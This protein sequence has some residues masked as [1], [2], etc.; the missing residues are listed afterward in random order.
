MF[1]HAPVTWTRTQAHKGSLRGPCKLTTDQL[2]RVIW[3]ANILSWV[4]PCS[5]SGKIIHCLRAQR[6]NITT[7][8]PYVSIWRPDDIAAD[9]QLDPLQQGTYQ[10]CHAEGHLTGGFISQPLPHLLDI[11][12]PLPVIAKAQVVFY[13]VPAS[14]FTSPTS[15]RLVWMKQL[16]KNNRLLLMGIPKHASIA[17]SSGN[18]LCIFRDPALKALHSRI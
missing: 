1:L 6:L 5:S 16:K 12:L 13:Y 10:S 18:L 17:E 15:V 11:I 9:S 14:Y 7:N 2:G 4:D 3:L 8:K